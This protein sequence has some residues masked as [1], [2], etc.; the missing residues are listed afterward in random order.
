MSEL[1]PGEVGYLI[2]GIKDVG[3]ARSGE[4]VTSADRPAKAAL[5]GYRDPKPMVFCGLYPIDG[6]QL[7]DLRD[8]LDRLKLNDAS[9]TFEPESSHTLGF[10]FR[11]GFLGLLH[12]EII[13]ERLEREFNLSLIATAPS[14]AY[15]VSLTDGSVLDID[16]PTELPD[17]E[18]SRSHR[19]ADVAG[20]DPHPER[21][22][23]DRDGAVPGP[24]GRAREDGVPVPRT[25][26]AHLQDPPGRGGGRLLRPI[27]EPHQGLREPRLRAVRVPRGQ[28]GQGRGAHQPRPGRRLLD[29]RA[30][31]PSRQLRPPDDREAPRDDPAPALRRPDPGRRRRDGSSPARR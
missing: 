11:C 3:G 10:G 18:P 23:G 24:P 31:R 14:V 21:V 7:P 30:P 6:D 2:A 16:N 20:H 17:A 9:F 4:T 5:P 8:A 28:P 13:R 19:G 15:R 27:E 29:H 1:G 26:R 22:H 25:G 12:M